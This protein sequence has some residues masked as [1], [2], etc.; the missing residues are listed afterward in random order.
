M[1]THDY[2]R[3]T[4]KAEIDLLPI[5]TKYYHQIDSKNDKLFIRKKEFKILP[6]LKFIRGKDTTIVIADTLVETCNI[7]IPFTIETEIVA[8][9]CTKFHNDYI[10]YEV[11]TKVYDSSISKLISDKLNYHLNGQTLNQAGIATYE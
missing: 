9:D 5:Q 6:K 8:K 3:R 11:K 4:F 1:K 2:L 7:N 10:E